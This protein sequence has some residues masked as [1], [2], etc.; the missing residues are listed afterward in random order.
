M[1][2]VINF[3][4]S[5]IKYNHEKEGRLKGRKDSTAKNVDEHLAKLPEEQRKALE[6]LRKVIK[7]AA[8]EAEEVI[9]YRIPTYRYHGPLV[10]FAAFKNHLSFYGVNRSLLETFKDELQEHKISGTTIHFI[11]ENPLPEA[12]VRKIVKKRMKENEESKK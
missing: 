6:W 9:S 3:I 7:E 1:H 2:L 8:P 11:P 4:I 5:V 10:H 12:L